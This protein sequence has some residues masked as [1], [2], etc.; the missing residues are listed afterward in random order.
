MSRRHHLANLRASSPLVL[1]S[2]LSCDFGNLEQEVR[3]MEDAGVSCL[4][5][6]VMDGHFVPNLSFGLPIVEAVRRATDLPL[7]VHLMIANPDSY[8][9]L[10]YEAGADILT[11][12]AEA[13]NDP[14]LLLRKIRALGA[15]AGL[16][17]NPPTPVETIQ[18]VLD[19]C[20]LVL[21][22]SVMPGFGGQTFNRVALEKLRQLKSLVGENVLLEVDGGVNAETIAECSQ[23]GA[24]LLVA[25]SAIFCQ[26]DYQESV[27]TLTQLAAC[28]G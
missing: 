2:L 20:D 10:F 25:G 24:Q 15:G 8:L 18:P 7:D 27:A 12:H 17:I 6:D 5:L 23:A 19:L 11:F 3:R 16:A 26:T 1:P 13:V 22:M 14:Q 4:H 28:G 9:Q 21:V